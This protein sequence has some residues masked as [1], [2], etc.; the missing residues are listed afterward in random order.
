MSRTA[1]I[2]RNTAETQIEVALGLDGSGRAEI[3]L[4]LEDDEELGPPCGRHAVD[5]GEQ[6]RVPLGGESRARGR[7]PVPPRTGPCE[8]RGDGEL[9]AG[10][11]VLDRQ[12][13]DPDSAEVQ[14]GQHDAYR[15]RWP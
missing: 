12:P 6:V 11:R 10:V 9:V 7:E 1:S 5:H 3:S 14:H 15:D 2:T 13:R 4:L 8:E